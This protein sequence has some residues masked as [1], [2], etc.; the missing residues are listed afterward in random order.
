MWMGY[1]EFTEAVRERMELVTGEE[2]KVSF[3]SLKKNNGIRQDG[4]E[5]REEGS[6]AGTVLRMERLYGLYRE[7]GMDHAINHIREMLGRKPDPAAWDIPGDWEE[8]RGNIRPVP[9]H[10]DWNREMLENCPHRNLLDLAVAYRLE[11][12]HE[13][14]RASTFIPAWFLNQW[15]ITEQELWE[16]AMENLQ[17]E[18]YKTESLPEFLGTF[19][20]PEQEGPAGT[21]Q[22]NFCGVARLYVLTNRDMHYGA[23]GILRKD[24]LEECAGKLQGNF[25]ILPSSVHEILLLAERPEME[26][27]DLREMVRCVNREEV[28]REEWLSENVYYYDREKGEIEIAE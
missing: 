5:I 27:E 20:C 12:E 11:L 6:R 15:G 21:G 17:G 14:Y 3:C 22:E 26:A 23:A 9:V 7:R 19:P 4:L 24:L 8:V 13:K 2:G 28:S 25:Y 18:A 16:T 1:E 10:A